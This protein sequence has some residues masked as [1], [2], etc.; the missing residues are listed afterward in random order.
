M[1]STVYL[2]LG[3]EP[4]WTVPKTSQLLAV[5]QIPLN[6]AD[7]VCLLYIILTAE[8]GKSSFA[9]WRY[10]Y[11]P[12]FIVMN[13]HKQ[14]IPNLIH[15]W[16]NRCSYIV[17]VISTWTL[18]FLWAAVIFT[19]S[20]EDNLNESLLPLMKYDCMQWYI[21]PIGGGISRTHCQRE[22]SVVQKDQLFPLG[23]KVQ[24]QT[25]NHTQT[26]SQRL[27]IFFHRRCSNEAKWSHFFFFFFLLKFTVC[28]ERK[29]QLSYWLNF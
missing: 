16:L 28:R 12:H 4:Q 26:H 14:H 6:T 22:A 10:S 17:W 13:V 24:V 9:F 20:M 2:I 5:T 18:L 19:T 25:H 3:H 1:S 11:F 15:I 8:A 21:R 7:P 27:T 23:G 29:Y